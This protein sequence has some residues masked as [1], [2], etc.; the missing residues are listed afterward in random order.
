MRASAS[1]SRRCQSC[2][3]ICVVYGL[4]G[5]GPAIRR[6]AAP[7]AGQSTLGIGGDVRVV[8]ADRAVDLAEDRHRGES[9]SRCRAQAGD[10]VGDLL[11]ERGRATRAGRACA[12]ASASSACACAIARS[13]A[14]SASSRGSSTLVARLA[15]H[16]RVGEVVDVL[17]GAGEVHELEPPAPAPASPS[18]RS[19]DEVLDR[20][21]VVVGRRARSALTARGIGVGEARRPALAAPR[22]P[23]AGRPRSSAMPGSLRPAPAATRPR[24]A[25]AAR[26]SP[27]S[28]KIGA[29]RVEPC[30]R[31]GRRRATARAA[32]SS[33]VIGNAGMR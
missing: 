26:I 13:A 6:S 27:Y 11:A 30:R 14:I 33:D 19:L 25:R 21:D 2:G 32:G 5:R 28:L 8:V 9:R 15:Q 18:R 16:Q 31:S 17:G 23:A 24:P 29:Q 4:P 1:Q 3:S 22:R 12:T 7:S 20:L 10:D